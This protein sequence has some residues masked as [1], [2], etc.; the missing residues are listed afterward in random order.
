MSLNRLAI[1]LSCLL[2]WLPASSA[3][4]TL[5]LLQN[6]GFEQ[7]AGGWSGLG[8]SADGCE[9]ESGNG[10]LQVASSGQA[11]FAQQIVPGP[12][13]DGSYTLTGSL[14][15]ASGSPDIQVILIWF[16]GGELDRDAQGITANDSYGSFSL[17]ASPPAG[18]ESL[19]VRIA[20]GAG[21]ASAICLDNL[22]LDGPP[23]PPPTAIPTATAPPSPAPTQTL[24]PTSTPKPSATA[25]PTSTPKPTATPKPTTTAKPR[26]TTAASAAPTFSFV[27][28]GFE[29]GLDGW[30]KYG[31]ELRAVGSPVNTG[32]LAGELFSSTDSTKWAYQTVRIDPA[33][34]YEF[35]GYVNREPGM[36]RAYLR[37]SWYASSDGSGQAI[38]T[39]DSTSAVEGAGGGFVYLTT[40]AAAPPPG[41]YSAK[42]RVMFTP[43]GAA[44]AAIQFDDLSFAATEPP[45]PTPES[46]ALVTDDQAEEPSQL[47]STGS[48]A[49]PTAVDESEPEAWDPAPGATA[50]Q[51]VKA[52]FVGSESPGEEPL[53]LTQPPP[54][55]DAVHT[56]WLLTGG[57]LLAAGLGGSYLFGRNRS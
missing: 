51:E 16:D 55:D 32:S 36:T 20:I 33:Q 37:I 24:A 13:G 45:S 43:G 40:G 53:S 18:A 38:S 19:R 7:G 10:A 11:T 4:T 2:A 44:P 47:A 31:G 28:G 21:E 14:L 48:S 27:N 56:V 26:A 5:E 39:T 6:G 50:V 23:P 42:P 29:Q 41:A 3:A 57:A 35:D 34:A 1:A 25:K 12:L 30:S 46:T 54:T 9:P 49:V 15:V 22:S 8:I 17:S 52:V